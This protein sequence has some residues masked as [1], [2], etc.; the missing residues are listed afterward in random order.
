MLFETFT[1]QNKKNKKYLNEI[2]RVSIVNKKFT[3]EKTNPTLCDFISKPSH[4]ELIL[5]KPM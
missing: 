1:K 3:R 2:D 4:P 5:T